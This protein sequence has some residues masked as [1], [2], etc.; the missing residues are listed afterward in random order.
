MRNSLAAFVAASTLGLANAAAG[1]T[2]VYSGS[3]TL[4]GLAVQGANGAALQTAAGYA[5]GSIVAFSLTLD[6]VPEFWNGPGQ[7][8]QYNPAGFSVTI[9]GVEV[10]SPPNAEASIVFSPPW[11]DGGIS[12]FDLVIS[13]FTDVFATPGN[14]G[15]QF[16]LGGVWQAGDGSL[17]TSTA[18]F[19]DVVGGAGVSLSVTNGSGSTFSDFT[20]FGDLGQ[21]FTLSITPAGTE[22]S[23]PSAA[24]EPS[25]WA[26]MIL[27]FAG[28]GATLRNRRRRVQPAVT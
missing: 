28:V 15:V 6:D 21:T 5:P 11:E 7:G 26:V 23:N 14:E 24:P 10:L 8:A 2:Y 3:G 4:A 27:G 1:A 22:G 12:Y 9:D 13:K 17:P 25:T 18:D 19:F 20:A 16:R